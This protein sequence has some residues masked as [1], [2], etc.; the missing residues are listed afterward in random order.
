[1][2]RN[3]APSPPKSIEEIVSQ[4]QRND[5]N[6]KKKVAL[7][8]LIKEMVAK[9][10]KDRDVAYISD[11]AALSPILKVEEFSN[12]CASFANRIAEGT[13]D[14]TNLT[15]NLL[16][17]FAYLLRH[18]NGELHAARGIGNAMMNLQNRL[19]NAVL[20]AQP[21]EKYELLC[22]LSA[23]LDAR[24]SLQEHGVDRVAIHEPLS[25]ELID[26]DDSPDLRT[27]QVA[28]YAYQALIGIPNNESLHAA[29]MR[30]G[31]ALTTAALR[32][33]GA[34]T[35]L[36]LSKIADV[37]ENPPDVAGL[38]KDLSELAKSLYEVYEGVGEM[39]DHLKFRRKPR[40]CKVVYYSPFHRLHF[41]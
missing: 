31:A 35:T 4:L 1:M 5:I 29:I 38:V 24:V 19:H 9:F 14:N 22:G 11:A 15:Q 7:D 3:T 28:R 26:L 10:E 41:P 27:S 21:V 12:I 23:V 13:T 16:T 2:A 20:T 37:L 33:A 17:S 8:A 18:S 36:D 6:P 40:F 39:K 32:I 30:H 34:V 25:K